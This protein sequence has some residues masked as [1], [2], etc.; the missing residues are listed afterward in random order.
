MI[1]NNNSKVAIIIPVKNEEQTIGEVLDKLLLNFNV[2][3]IVVID[4]SSSDRTA[5]IARYK[6]VRIIQGKGIGKG[7]ALRKAID[8]VTSDIILFIDADGSHNPDDISSLI[9]PIIDDNADL[10]IA[11]RIKGGSE[12]FSGNIKNIMHYFGNVLASFIVNLIWGHGKK[13]VTDCNNGFR[14]IRT[15]VA[16]Q[17]DLKENS[18]AIEQEMVIKCLR[19]GYRISE[20]PSYESKRK[21]GK[22]HINLVTMLPRYIWCFIKNLF[23]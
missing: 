22:S 12:E 14:A 1:V 10:V 15:N 20:I 21:Y 5:E 23:N 16:K 11:S 18:F 6:N 4:D 2:D 9:Q 19:M 8:N 7:A 3:N 17:L 13:I